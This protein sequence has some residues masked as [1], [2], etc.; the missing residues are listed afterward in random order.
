M[1]RRTLP[2]LVICA[3]LLAALLSLFSS[4]TLAEDAIV[5]V[6]PADT[7]LETPIDTPTEIPTDVPTDAPMS[8]PTNTPTQPPSHTPSETPT[9]I[10]TN[11]PTNTSTVTERATRTPTNTPTRTPTPTPT[12]TATRTPTPTNT[13]TKTPKHTATHTPTNTPTNTPTPTSTLWPDQR[14]A[15][16]PLIDQDRFAPSALSQPANGEFEDESK[17]V[18][19]ES[20]DGKGAQGALI[21]T[22]GEKNLPGTSGTHFVWLGGVRRQTNQIAQ[23]LTLSPYHAGLRLKYRYWSYSEEQACNGEDLVVIRVGASEATFPLCRAATTQ[24]WAE[25]ALD[26]AGTT[27]GQAVTLSFTSML[28]DDGR[29]SNFFLDNVRLCSTDP[30]AASGDKCP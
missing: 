16:L 6:P 12:N 10:P 27:Y 23:V 2:I 17:V 25:G 9:S 3:L 20:I 15:Y 18:W 29:N 5:D 30:N 24:D 28:D 8:T 4:P 7:P 13:P 11:T 21:Y 1:S 14:K 19:T 26:V 22:T